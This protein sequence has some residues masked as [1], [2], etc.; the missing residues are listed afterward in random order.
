MTS[1]LSKSCWHYRGPIP[2]IFIAIQKQSDCFCRLRTFWFK[3]PILS[4]NVLIFHDRPA[5]RWKLYGLPVSDRFFK[6]TRV[7]FLE[8]V[9][10]PY[11]SL[12]YLLDGCRQL[13]TKSILCARTAHRRSASWTGSITARSLYAQRL[14]S[15]TIVCASAVGIYT[16]SPNVVLSR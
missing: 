11:E 7:D 1:S 14:I 4:P 9:F 6:I 2:L 8:L 12:R 10:Q 13:P 5:S 16:Q 15:R 3:Q